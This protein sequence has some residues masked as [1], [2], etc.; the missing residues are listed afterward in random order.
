[1]RVEK[2][3]IYSIILHLYNMSLKIAEYLVYCLGA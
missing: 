1:M 3:Y 2:D